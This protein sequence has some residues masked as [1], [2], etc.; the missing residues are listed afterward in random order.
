MKKSFL[1]S[2]SPQ[3]I[4]EFA[5]QEH[6]VGKGKFIRKLIENK[7]IKSCLFYGPSGTGKTVLANI[8]AENINAKVFKL[9]ATTS[10]VND[11]KKIV[12]YARGSF[13]NETI[14]VILD[15]IHHFNKTQQNVLLPSIEKEEIYLIGI[16]TE[17]PFFYIN[18]ALLSRFLI[19]EFKPHTAKSLSQIIDLAIKKGFNGKLKIEEKAREALIKYADGDA[20]KLLNFLHAASMIAENNTI[21]LDI[22]KDLFSK[23]YVSYDKKDDEHYDTI[24]A[25]I[26]SMR[27]SDPDATVYWL[28][29]MLYAGE[30]PLFIARRIVICASE[31]VGLAN[32]MALVVA[33]S[34]FDAVK[35][36]GMPEAK[37]ILSQAA[38]YVAVS[39]KSNSSYMAVNKAMD[40]VENGPVRRV[41]VHLKDANLDSDFFGDGRD[42][43]YPHDYPGHYVKQ[44]YMPEPKRFYIPSDSGLEKEIK[45]KLNKL[46]GVKEE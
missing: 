2:V 33:Q 10:S 43:K 30:D 25:F 12:E 46:K 37:I 7:I 8:I 23:R 1:S 26:K 24:S 15:E 22:L 19:F 4:D 44:E 31:D 14:L 3:N 21:T 41:P 18:K 36:I 29:R 45:K 13:N 5:G 40:E 17:N 38:I 27:G 34:A 35:N 28:A 6:L 39:P 11:F 32:P 42:Y 9:N 20:R 16:T